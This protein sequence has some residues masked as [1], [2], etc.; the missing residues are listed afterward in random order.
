MWLPIEG[1]S[2]TYMRAHRL[3]RTYVP[4]AILTM[5]GTLPAM[6][7]DGDNIRPSAAGLAFVALLLVGVA[8]GSTVAWALL[9]IWNAFLAF[10]IAA[11]VGGSWLP[12]APLL[13]LNAVL[14]LGL[15]LA[16]SM[17]AHLGVRR[18]HAAAPH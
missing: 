8:R 18:E 14:C 17:R 9:L 11:T 15:L 2:V 6:L 7:I 12:G 16:P 5:F 3:P 13:L 4:L 1:T 10:S